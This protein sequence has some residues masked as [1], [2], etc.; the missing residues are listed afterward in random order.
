[1]VDPATDHL[2]LSSGRRSPTG[3]A[4][5]AFAALGAFA[6]L[7]AFAARRCSSG[8]RQK[9]IGLCRGQL[10]RRKSE[11]VVAADG[12]LPGPADKFIFSCLR[13]PF[14]VATFAWFCAFALM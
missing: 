8:V 5:D 14:G 3:Y 9:I 13:S 7:A 1:L 2:F 6:T 11:M 4:F 10:I 12:S